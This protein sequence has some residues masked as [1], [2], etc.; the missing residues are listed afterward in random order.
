MQFMAPLKHDN[1]SLQWEKIKVK[2]GFDDLTAMIIKIILR[3]KKTK[4]SMPN[5]GGGG[6][7]RN[8][9]F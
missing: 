9:W 1:V 6:K 2:V 8:H 7:H 4:L 5:T 3:A